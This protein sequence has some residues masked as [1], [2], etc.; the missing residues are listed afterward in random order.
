MVFNLFIFL[1]VAIL[2]ELA[3]AGATEREKVGGVDV[4]LKGFEALDTPPVGV[5]YN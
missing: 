2:F 3:D 5:R 1:E 4:D